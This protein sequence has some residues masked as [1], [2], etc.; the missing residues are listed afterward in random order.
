MNGSWECW[1]VLVCG[2]FRW[3]RMFMEVG[4]FLSRKVRRFRWF[5]EVQG[6]WERLGSLGRFRVLLFNVALGWM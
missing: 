5:R 6:V 4:S 2:R 1:V 3:F